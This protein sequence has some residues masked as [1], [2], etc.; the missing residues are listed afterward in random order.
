MGSIPS[1][2]FP[3]SWLIWGCR[4]GALCTCSELARTETHWNG[5]TCLGPALVLTARGRDDSSCLLPGDKPI[6]LTHP[7]TPPWMEATSWA[8]DPKS[9]RA[10]GSYLHNIP[11]RMPFIP[12]AEEEINKTSKIQIK[13][14]P[15]YDITPVITANRHNIGNNRCGQWCGERGNA[16]HCW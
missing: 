12:G 5:S 6:D 1:A 11:P 14:K 9:D 7:R 8:E 16:L 2:Q 15:R 3:P 13:T 4:Q 10:V